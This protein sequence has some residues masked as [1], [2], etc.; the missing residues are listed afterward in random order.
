MGNCCT[1]KVQKERYSYKINRNWSFSEDAINEP[2]LI[3][4][5][6]LKKVPTQTIVGICNSCR[7]IIGH[8]F[9]V[10]QE[11]QCMVCLH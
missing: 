1:E 5:I 2:F 9:C 10:H 8:S 6:C 4:K 3:C 7:T 11:H